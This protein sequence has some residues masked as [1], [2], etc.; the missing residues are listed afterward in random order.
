VSTGHASKD[1]AFRP[2]CSR[3]A[4][5]RLLVA[6]SRFTRPA[7]P[8]RR[9][10]AVKGQSPGPQSPNSRWRHP[11]PRILLLEASY[12][13]PVATGAP[14]MPVI[15][16][17]SPCLLQRPRASAVRRVPPER[18]YA[19][20][21]WAHA[22]RD[23]RRSSVFPHTRPGTGVTA[24]LG[25]SAPRRCHGSCSHRSA[26]GDQRRRQT[27]RVRDMRNRSVLQHGMFPP[28]HC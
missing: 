20:L 1:R 15:G 22:R 12:R 19:L 6:E 13:Q 4:P 9:A 23:R 17:P 25:S 26:R 18:R 3:V 5:L 8:H 21:A 11:S 2:A 24:R 14:G 7:I 16:P 27:H 10:L 28:T